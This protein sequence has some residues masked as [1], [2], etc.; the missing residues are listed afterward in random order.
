MTLHDIHKIVCT[1]KHSA[2]HRIAQDR[3]ARQRARQGTALHDAALLSYSFGALLGGAE[4]MISQ[5]EIIN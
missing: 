5:A 2:R 3:S 1:A 4:L